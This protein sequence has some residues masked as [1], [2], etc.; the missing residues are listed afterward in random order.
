VGGLR[1]FYHPDFVVPFSSRGPVSPFYI[2]PDL[3]A[4]GVYV[5]TTTVGGRYNLT[6]GTSIAAPHVTGAIALLLQ[7]YPNLDPLSV[8]SLLATTTDPVTDAYGKIFS[9]EVSGSGR[10]NITRADSANLIIIPHSLVFNLSYDKLKESKFLNIRSIDGSIIPKLKMQFHSNES[11][12]AFNYSISNNTINVQITGN[13]KKFGDYEGFITVDDSKTL[14]RIPV[15][16]HL[17]KGTLKV[18]QNNEKINFSINY[19]DRWSYAK[20]SLMLASSH[21]V[22][23]IGITPQDTRSMLIHKSGE[24]WIQADIMAGNKTDHAYQTLMAN[25]VKEN[26]DIEDILRIPIKQVVIISFILII[27]ITVGLVGRH[28]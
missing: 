22:K 23:T 26:I 16:I 25:N 4:P 2:K 6:S 14:Y 12:L 13:L 5:N 27:V 1:I 21:E 8:A 3:V 10:L 7:K 17:T 9:I 20:I 24:Y 28:R 15:L 11:S 19:P 18:D